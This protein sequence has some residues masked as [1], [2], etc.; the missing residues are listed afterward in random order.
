MKNCTVFGLAF[1]VIKDKTRK[2]GFAP[3]QT[4]LGSGKNLFGLARLEG[5]AAIAKLGFAQKIVVIGG[6]EGRYKE[7][8]P[9]INR[10]K[11]YVTTFDLMAA[12]SPLRMRSAASVQPM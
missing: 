7:V 9:L 8:A 4:D 5:F 10:A 11:S 6:N 3:A 2:S 1:D 12:F